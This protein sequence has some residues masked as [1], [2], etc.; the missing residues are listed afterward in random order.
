MADVIDLFGRAMAAQRPR[1]E[2]RPCCPAADG[3]PAARLFLVFRN[4][5]YLVLNY[6]DLESIGNPPGVP[7]ND[8][9]MLRFRG[10]VVREVRIEGKRLLDV[11]D[12]LWKRLTTKIEETPNGWIGRMDGSTAVVTRISVR[13]IRG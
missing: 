10:S 5:D 6:D 8:V 2:Y 9:A 1:K 12:Y 11:V 13:E 4:N 7:P 3:M